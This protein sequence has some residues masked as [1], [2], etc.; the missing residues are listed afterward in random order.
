[1]TSNL[2]DQKTIDLNAEVIISKESDL[3]DL[4]DNLR[5]QHDVIKNEAGE[6][7]LLRHADVMAAALDDQ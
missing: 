2:L 7:V 1:M 3:R 4:T 6:W 5:Q